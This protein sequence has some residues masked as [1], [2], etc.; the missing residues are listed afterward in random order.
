MDYHMSAGECGV[1]LWY[2]RRHGRPKEPDAT[3]SESMAK[4]KQSDIKLVKGVAV[5]DGRPTL[6]LDGSR[7]VSLPPSNLL[8]SPQL[9]PSASPAGLGQPLYSKTSHLLEMCG[10]E[11]T[12]SPTPRVG[13]CVNFFSQD[14]GHLGNLVFHNPHTPTSPLAT[15]AQFSSTDGL[16]LQDDV[17]VSIQ[18]VMLEPN[19]I[20]RLG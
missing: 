13:A 11:D 3:E 5:Q 19:S 6:V 16:E 20:A 7:I 4:K 18:F 12:P 17:L 1:S 8:P 9:Q 14:H 10:H 15:H 2:E